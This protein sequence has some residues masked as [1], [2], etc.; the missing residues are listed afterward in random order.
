MSRLGYQFSFKCNCYGI[1]AIL[2]FISESYSCVIY[3]YIIVDIFIQS[4]FNIEMTQII[5]TLPFKDKDPFIMHS[6]YPPNEHIFFV[7]TNSRCCFDI[8]MTLSLL[9]VSAAQDVLADIDGWRPSDARSQGISCMAFTF[10]SLEYSNFIASRIKPFVAN[11]LCIII[12]AQL[13]WG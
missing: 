8:K 13:N 1:D 5:Q 10:L 7:K 2:C 11:H 12:M 9:L 3:R 4:S 6:H